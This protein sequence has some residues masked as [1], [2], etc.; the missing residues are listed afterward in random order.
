M[1]KYRKPTD[2]GFV[3]GITARLSF[4]VGAIAAAALWPFMKV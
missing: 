3:C 2:N 1:K 4:E